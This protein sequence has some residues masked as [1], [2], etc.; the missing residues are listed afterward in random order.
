MNFCKDCQFFSADKTCR[1][2]PPSSR[3]SCWPTM[4]DEDW[5]GEFKAMN[6]PIVTTVVVQTTPKSLDEP[7]PIIMEALEEGVAPKI[8]FQKPKKPESLKDIQASPLFS[9]GQA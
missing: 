3:P 2:Y 4:K 7:R 6:N 9:G 5:C 8:R 1:R